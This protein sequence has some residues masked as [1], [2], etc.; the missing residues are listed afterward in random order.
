MYINANDI[1]EW[2]KTITRAADDIACL[3]GNVSEELVGRL[4]STIKDMGFLVAYAASTL[5]AECDCTVNEEAAEIREMITER[6][7]RED[8]RLF[9]AIVEKR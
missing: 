2:K 6:L 7:K 3:R 5:K 8:G 4:A 9:D 1:S